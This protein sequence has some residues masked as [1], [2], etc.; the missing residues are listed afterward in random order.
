M[1]KKKGSPST[2]PMKIQPLKAAVTL[3]TG[4]S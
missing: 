1:I 2:G 3:A 4:N